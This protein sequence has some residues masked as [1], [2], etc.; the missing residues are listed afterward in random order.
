MDSYFEEIEEED[1]SEYLARYERRQR[2]RQERQRRLIRQRMVKRTLYLGVFAVVII[3]GTIVAVRFG[4]GR[5]KED[6]WQ[7]Q[8]RTVKDVELT[9]GDGAC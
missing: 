4:S 9:D 1:E 2:M 6:D 8:L 7:Q 3:M 5:Q